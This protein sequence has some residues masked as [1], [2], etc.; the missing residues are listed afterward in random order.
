[1]YSLGEQKEGVLEGSQTPDPGKCSWDYAKRKDGVGKD[2][3]IY[4]GNHKGKE[5]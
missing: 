5:L 3:R 4:C 2:I 1:V